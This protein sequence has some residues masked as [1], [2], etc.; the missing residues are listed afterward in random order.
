MQQLDMFLN[1]METKSI[2]VTSSIMDLTQSAV[3]KSLKELE[4]TIGAELFERTSSGLRPT[5]H[6]LL[7]ERYAHDVIHGFNLLNRQLHA[8][9]NEKIDPLNVGA[10]AGGAHFFL[11]R[12]IRHSLDKPPI[13]I[14]TRIEDS[15]SLVEKLVDGALDVV[16]THAATAP[17]ASLICTVPAGRDSIVAVAHPDHPV[18]HDDR[19]YHHHAWMLPHADEPIRK[20]IEQRM[21]EA[22]HAL[23]KALVECS[24]GLSAPELAMHNDIIVW[25]THAVAIPWIARGDLRCVALPFEP[26][27]LNYCP[28]RLRKRRLPIPGL[29]LWAELLRELRARRH[30]LRQGMQQIA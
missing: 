20:L 5:P 4:C 22:G 2:R 27:M 19:T 3:S 10:T 30:W 9:A 14:R 11:M 17:P 29:T 28:M 6:S 7:L 13:R 21:I 18:F 23:P 15:H 1:L 16:I 25:T 12:L 24:L 26:P 8:Q